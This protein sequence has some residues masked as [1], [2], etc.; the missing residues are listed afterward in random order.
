M[1]ER[2]SGVDQGEPIHVAR[3]PILR[4]SGQ[5]Y[6][7]ELLYRQGA[8]PATADCPS[9]LATARIL[10]EGLLAI[11]LDTLTGGRP[12][13]VPFTRALLASD[14]ASLFPPA[15]LVL[16]VRE[17]IGVD[18]ETVAACARLAGSGYAICLEPFVLGSPLEAL[19]PSARF[20]KV[21]AL[22]TSLDDCAAVAPLARTHGVQLVAQGVDSPEIAH[23]L[24]ELGYHF[25]QGRHFARP[26]TFSS[27][28]VRATD[29]GHTRLIR[30][31]NRPGL[32]VS[33][34]EEIVKDD[35]VLSYR[36]LRAINSPAFALHREVTSI[37][38]AVVM[39]GQERV[40][41]WLMIWALAGMNGGPANELLAVAVLRARC[42]E[43][44][45]AYLEEDPGSYFLLGLCSLLDA[46]L[47]KP[48][49]DV[50][51]DIPLAAPVRDALLGS[52]GRAR[53]VLDAVIA[54]EQGEWGAAA[55]RMR[56]LDVPLR[57][58]AWAYTDALRWARTLQADTEMAA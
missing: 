19:L 37:R 57:T 24:Q 18:E 45:G 35:P 34:I 38:Q 16:Q 20:L 5:V 40:R 12:A 55:E 43:E 25:F 50:L 41:K 14:A 6:G 9:D 31:L 32:T 39:L 13:F 15:S 47:R 58:L 48:L 42:C 2:T 28:P 22:T 54:Y 27:A 23:R 4:A 17:D 3:Q 7:Y 10:S 21:D 46:I 29:V 30:A 52:T 51:T 36:V 53:D 33:H 11:G 49:K 44:M 8:D 56:A 26:T 1:T